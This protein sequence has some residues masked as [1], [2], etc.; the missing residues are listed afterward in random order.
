MPLNLEAK[1]D[2]MNRPLLAATLAVSLALAACGKSDVPA[3]VA[4]ADAGTTNAFSQ[5]GTPV[6]QFDPCS[7]LSVAEAEAALGTR[8]AV[9][10]YRTSEGQAARGGAP[11]ADGD[12]CYYATADFH[13]LHVTAAEHGAPQVL[14][15]LRKINGLVKKQ[16]GKEVVL[17]KGTNLDGD[18]D[19]AE[20]I[21]CCRLMAVK[22]ER[23][24]TVDIGGSKAT[25][26]QAATLADAALKRFD[27][28]LPIDGTAAAGAARTLMARRPQLDAPCA[29]LTRAA[30]EAI[31]GPLSAEPIARRDACELHGAKGAFA[32]QLADAAGGYAAMRK[33]S[34]SQGGDAGAIARRAGRDDLNDQ[35]RGVLQNLAGGL[36]LKPLDNPAWDQGVVSMRG[37]YVV[38]KD[39]RIGCSTTLN[40]AQV[41][42]CTQLA[43]AVTSRF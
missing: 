13:N 1:D 19:D 16:S 14:A 18:W 3:A 34:A 11:A 40:A 33:M 28:P 29:M 32:W 21:A 9:P 5:L 23:G 43:A 20:L 27:K 24:V 2:S 35:S 6:L 17:S 42:I 25:L 38:K 15:T 7:L 30:A 8:L 22:G 26:A 37:L 41:D 36:D 12:T 39:V 4:V 31:V 10:P